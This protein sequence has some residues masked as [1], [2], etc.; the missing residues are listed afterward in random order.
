M[1]GMFPLG[2]GIGRVRAI[3]GILRQHKGR[4]SMSELATESEEDI[5][6]LLPL[7]D[8]CKLLGLTT[9]KKSALQLT[10]KGEKLTFSNFSKTM[11]DSLVSVEPFKSTIM[12]LGDGEVQ[13]KDLFTMLRA[14][15]IVLHED[16]TVNDQMLKKLLI[17]WGVRSKLIVYN[18]EN[19]TWRTH[20]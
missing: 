19:D 18:V 20:R 6:D 13:T 2:T 11:K 14:K 16:E 15:G 8:A 10:D 9:I 5:D 17:R 7:I 3:I 12:I 1:E 4:M